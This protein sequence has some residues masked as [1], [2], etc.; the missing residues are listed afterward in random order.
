MKATNEEFHNFLFKT[1]HFC[2]QRSFKYFW[3]PTL[4]SISISRIHWPPILPQIWKDSLWFSQQGSFIFTF[5]YVMESNL[6]FCC[7]FQVESCFTS[8]LHYNFFILKSTCFL[9]I[10]KYFWNSSDL[11]QSSYSEFEIKGPGKSGTFA[12]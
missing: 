10:P 6:Q 1:S 5:F 8:W 9:I 2:K 7:R 11:R 3:I 12:W 4:L